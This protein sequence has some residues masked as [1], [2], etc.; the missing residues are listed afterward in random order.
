MSLKKQCTIVRE[1]EIEGKGLFTSEPVRVRFKPAPP[2]SGVVF[3]RTDQG[4]PIRIPAK[5]E[6]ITRKPRRTSLRN[7]TVAV[8]TVEHCLAAVSGL[9]LDNL[10]IELTGPELPGLDGSCEPFVRALEDAGIAEQEV[11]PQIYTITEPITVREN[12]A[13][14]AALPGE[15]AELTILYDL[16]YS[17]HG[18]IGRQVYAI[19][20]TRED[21]LKNVAPSRTFLLES[22]AE[23]LR[24]SGY[25]KHLTYQDILVLNQKG[26]IENTLRFADECVRHKILDLIGDLAVLGRRIQGRIVCYKSGHSLNQGLVRELSSRIN[27]IELNRRMISKPILD[28][29]QIERILP[30]RYPFLLVDRIIEID[31]EKRAVGIKNVTINEPF[32]QGHFPK[33]PIMPGVMIVEALAQLAGVLLSQKLEHTGKL[34]VLLS[35]DRVKMRRPVIPGDQLI[36]EAQTLRVKQR[37]GHVR[38]TARVGEAMAAEATIKF[39][40]VDAES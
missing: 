6:N 2:N 31:G 5:P 27:R 7:G 3:V 15:K 22:E 34:A 36:L 10:E 14:I 17:Q 19:N 13:M 39:M 18:A 20:L 35:M 12:D 8:E 33:Q 38:C 9:G 23:H 30:H 24:K 28:I 26:P 29:R 25:G 32:F 1:T 11:S 21:F 16:D 4:N 40:L 37:T